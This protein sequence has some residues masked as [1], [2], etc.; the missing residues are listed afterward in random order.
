MHDRLTDAELLAAWDLGSA[1]GPIDRA[2]LLL[3]AA[4]ERED[5][6]AAISLAERDRRLLR[7]RAAGFGDRMDCLAACPTCGTGVELTTSAEALAAALP[8]S[9]AR[10]FRVGVH[11]IDLR[12]L[13]SRDL[14]AV[15]GCADR[16]EA[17]T[18]LFERS[19]ASPLPDLGPAER[20]RLD[21]AVAAQ[22]EAAELA[23]AMD[24]PDCGNA[25]TEVLDVARFVWE[26]FEAAALRLMAD[27][28]EL[29]RAFHWSEAEVLALGPRRRRAY[30]AL[31]RAT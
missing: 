20:R 7:L 28:A 6:L 19:L 17:E 9:K 4:G 22:A 12:P 11:R 24:C 21:E 25:W 5:D 3:W 29:A 26:E 16:A 13:D 8:E 10:E 23:L 14:A 18:M 27:V 1:R 30:L 15:A 31:A 2:L